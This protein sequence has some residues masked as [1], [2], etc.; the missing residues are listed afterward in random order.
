MYKSTNKFMK[1]KI[2]RKTC[3]RIKV[4]SCSFWAK[5]TL[6]QDVFARSDKNSPKFSFVKITIQLLVSKWQLSLQLDLTRKK[7]SS[8]VSFF[9]Q[10]IKMQ[11]IRLQSFNIQTYFS[12]FLWFFSLKCWFKG[13]IISTVPLSIQTDVFW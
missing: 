13:Q 1:M 4:R 10:C 9:I 8:K 6:W 7:V 5:R 2:K 11:L 12:Q 3:I